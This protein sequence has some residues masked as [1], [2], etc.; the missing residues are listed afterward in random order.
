MRNI[1]YTRRKYE[2]INPA[3]FDQEITPLIQSFTTNDSGEKI[4][5][6]TPGTTIRAMVDKINSSEEDSDFYK[7]NQFAKDVIV[8]ITYTNQ[9]LLNNQ[10]R[11]LWSGKNLEIIDTTEAYARGRW[12]RIKCMILD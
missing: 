4:S 3:A 11:I 6:F 5:S 2:K 7:R 8:I 9:D 1:L 10:N 12:I